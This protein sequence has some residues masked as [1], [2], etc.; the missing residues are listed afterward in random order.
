MSCGVPDG[1]CFDLDNPPAHAA[2]RK[3][4]DQR[5]TDQV[6]G[7]LDSVDGKFAPA[8]SPRRLPARKR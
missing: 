7:E 5:F 6:A 4:V 2:F 1:I 8:K 3:V